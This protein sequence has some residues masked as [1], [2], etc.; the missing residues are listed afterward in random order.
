VLQPTFEPVEALRLME[1]ERVTRAFAW[2]HQ[3]E[4]LA[5]APNW[6]SVDLSSLRY[7]DP[8]TRLGQHPTVAS[9][10]TDP[11]QA[12]GNTETFTLS[13]AFPSCTPPEIAG[14]THGE[15]LP[16]NTIKIVDPL[17]GKTV[18]RGV[19][20]EIAVKGPTLMLGYL[21]IPL[22]ET[23]DSEGFFSTGDGG[24]IDE[25]D[26]LVWEGRLTD[27]I[28]TGGA[29]V[30]PVEVDA[31]LTACTGVKVSRTVGVPHDSLGEIV[32]TCI[33]P[34][35][36]AV[37]DEAAIREF[38]KTRLASYKVPRRVLFVREDE[39]SLT[40]SA[41]VRLS[42]LRELAVKRLTNDQG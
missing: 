25:R 1:I 15:A 32:V 33:V 24:F 7:V 3:Y 2:P 39:L 30:S 28:K 18:P 38:L 20:G 13:A 21:G 4:Q 16:G 14:K 37:L 9:T 42:E 34:H 10:W 19:R 27:I 12:Y 5:A 41:K 22:D 29:N 6:P 23:L 35:A 31:V 17:T 40:G 26:R 11:N 36:A 8:Q